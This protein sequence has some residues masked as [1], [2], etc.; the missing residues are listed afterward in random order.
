MV[1]LIATPLARRA[2]I[3]RGVLAYPTQR[4]VHSEP[5]PYLGGLGILAG[6]V[7]GCAFLPAPDPHVLGLA[8]GA[9]LIA[10]VGVYD[11]AKGMH[12]TLKLAMQLAV[13][14]GVWLCGVRIEMWSPPFTEEYV[15]LGMASAALTALWLVAVMN[16]INFIDGL[17]GLAGG[18]SAIAGMALTGIA[19]WWL[20]VK[21]GATYE[22]MEVAVLGAA[23][24]GA[25]LGFLRYNFHPAR[26]FMGDSGALTLGLWLASLSVLGAFK[27]TLLYLCPIVLLGLPLSDTAWAALRRLWRRQSPATADRAHIHHRVLGRVEHQ[28]TAVLILYAVSL[29]LAGVAIW[30]ARP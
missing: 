24:V 2:A 22:R 6:L 4:G 12:W 19:L 26:V 23:L 7:A 28:R 21:G 14:L 9:I 15:D 3:A 1:A 27:S 30:L 20:E 10:A 5:I 18:V 29:G 13:A 8:A 25:C 11:D 16:A 17:D